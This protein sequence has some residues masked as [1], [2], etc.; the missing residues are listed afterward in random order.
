[1]CYNLPVEAGMKIAE[2]LA[3]AWLLKK[4]ECGEA[5]EPKKP[6][7]DFGLEYSTSRGRRI[8]FL[9]FLAASITALVSLFIHPFIALFAVF[10]A[11]GGLVCPFIKVQSPGT[12]VRPE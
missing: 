3:L 5:P 2:I 10:I 12:E 1:M 6:G 11:T 4:P 7:Y 8:G 9:V